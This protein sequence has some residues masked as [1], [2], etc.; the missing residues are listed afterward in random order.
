MSD[1]PRDIVEKDFTDGDID[2]ST[3]DGKAVA[4]VRRDFRKAGRYLDKWHKECI[5]RY[6]HYVAPGLEKNILKAKQFPVP[7][8]TEQVDQFVADSMDKLF[9]KNEPCSLYGRNEEDKD[10]ADTKREFIKYQDEVDNIQD[11]VEQDLKH[12]AIYG[13][14]PKV[15][16]YKEETTTEERIEQVPIMGQNGLPIMGFDGMT[17]IMEEKVQEVEVYTYQGATVE[18]VD[19]IDFFFTA[20]KRDVYD[21]YPFM[22]GS[23]R[24][25]EWF[26]SKPYIKQENIK[27]L[28]D[29]ERGVHDDDDLLGERREVQGYSKDDITSHDKEY[30]YVEWY[31]HGDIGDGW[32]LYII[33]VVNDKILMR[34]EEEKEAFDLGHPNIVVGTIAKDFGEVKGFSLIDKF[35]SVQHAMDSLMGMWLKSLRQ[36]VNHMY[37]ANKNAMVKK[38]ELLNEQGKIIW[39]HTDVDKAIKRFEQQQISRD[40]YSGLAML[41]QMGQF[42]SGQND[43]SGGVAQEGVDTLGEAQMLNTQAALRA[44]GGYLRTFERTCVEPTWRMRNKINMTF[45][46]DVGYL[47]SVLDKGIVNWKTISKAQI[48]SHVDFVCEAS[49]R[50]NQRA[51]IISQVL[52]ALNLTIKMG[53][54]LGPIPIIKLL[55]KLYEEGFGWGRDTIKE[56]LPIEAIAQQLL[57]KQT[58]DQT[59]GQGERPQNMPQPKSEGD[60]IQGANARN[61]APVGMVT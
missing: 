35:H 45:V 58:Q 23:R 53:E 52:Q 19:P 39:T 54:I 42:S 48:R 21:E 56:M 50:E 7:F 17:P 6:K 33:G 38:G 61:A 25:L 11:K 31:G 40:I 20:E 60:A 12:C 26:K 2:L 1:D 22:I 36:T 32:K 4:I 41:R 8:T 18:L 43:P 57:M 9:Y 27:L 46:T 59:A 24:T 16:N 47:Y 37:V 44:K 3:P 13:I 29:E 5:E 10:D 28:T 15:I 49:N 30:E 14:A 34:L 51:V 55:E